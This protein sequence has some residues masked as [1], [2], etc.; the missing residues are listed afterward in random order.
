MFKPLHDFLGSGY[1]LLDSLTDDLAERMA[2]LDSPADSS[3]ANVAAK[4]ALAAL[5][6]KFMQADSIL[7]EMQSRLSTLV[8]KF[9]AAISDTEDDPVTS[10]MLQDMTQKLEKYHWMLRRQ[11]EKRETVSKEAAAR[12]LASFIK[13]SQW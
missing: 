1:E 10:N 7:V 5:P 2:T 6:T 13:V 3:S 9:K 12:V 11:N 8:D 4:S